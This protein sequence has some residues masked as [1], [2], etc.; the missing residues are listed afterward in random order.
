VVLFSGLTAERGDAQVT[1][2]GPVST[3]TWR[4]RLDAATAGEVLIVTVSG[5]LGKRSSGALIERI[6]GAIDEGHRRIVLDLQ[7]VDYISSAGL[8][9]LDAIA[10]R[11]HHAG[12][13]IVLCELAESVALA[14]ELSGMRQH[15]AIE[16]CRV[17]AV[18]ALNFTRTGC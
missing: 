17:D 1:A 16:S 6:V 13:H 10:G 3:R 2:A 18:A 5:R 9:A 8:L 14:F 11:M 12:G 7:D 4:F 15:F